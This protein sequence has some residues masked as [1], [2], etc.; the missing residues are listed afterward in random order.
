MVVVT[1]AMVVTAVI[2]VNTRTI[3]TIFVGAIV[4]TASWAAAVTS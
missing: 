4:I 1:A 2:L 3:A